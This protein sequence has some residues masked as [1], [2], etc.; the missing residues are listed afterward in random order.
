LE[1]VSG[2]ICSSGHCTEAKKEGEVCMS[3]DACASK[4]VCY[5]RKCVPFEEANDEVDLAGD[6]VASLVEIEGQC[7]NRE[8]LLAEARSIQEKAQAA[9]A[10]AMELNALLVEKVEEYARQ[11][12]PGDKVDRT[13]MDFCDPQLRA[14]VLEELKRTVDNGVQKPVR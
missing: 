3:P 9:A 1:C 11:K 12:N 2:L 5:A 13:A 10:E 6:G 8:R 7:A 4:L 14:A